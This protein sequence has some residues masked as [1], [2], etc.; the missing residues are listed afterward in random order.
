M[1][2]T[3]SRT[4][5]HHFFPAL[6]AV[7]SAACLAPS[8]P[9][10]KAPSSET[11]WHIVGMLFSALIAGGAALWAT[12]STMKNARELQNRDRRL[13]EQSVAAL[14]SADLHRRLI[15][16]VYLLSQ[17]EAVKVREL[18]AMDTTFK[19]LGAALPK[20]GALGPQG[21]HYLLTIFSGLELLAK[22]AEDQNWQG[23]SERMQDVGLHIG[24][25][26]KAL[27][28]SYKLDLPEPLEKAGLDLE[29]VGLQELKKL[30]L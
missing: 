2:H 20:L 26:V 24:R 18:A 30:G 11:M 5:R 27:G 6:A 25:G 9:W 17:P 29:A 23:L 15:L 1:K 14:L 19:V 13:E 22:A 7:A 16:L 8:D 4:H 28:E 21:A 12:R 3:R 10:F